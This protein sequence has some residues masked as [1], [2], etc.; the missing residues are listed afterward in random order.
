MFRTTIKSLPC[1][2]AVT[3]L[4]AVSSARA[5]YVQQQIAPSSKA[6]AGYAGHNDPWWKHAVVYEVYPR[7]FV[8]SDG[9]GV[10]D[11][12]GVTE[13]LD[14]LQQLG[15]DAIWLA[16]MYPSPQ[17]DFGYDI[18]DY[19]AVDP[20]Y[21]SLADFDR[22]LEKAKQ[23][24]LRI[25]LDMVLNHT[26]DKSPWFLESA[27]SRT[28]PKAAWYIWSDGVSAATA[29][30][31]DFQ[32]K[33]VQRGPKGQVVPPNNWTSAFGGS[34]WTWA[35][36]RQQFY[37]HM[38]YAGQPDLNWRNPDVDKAMFAVMRFWLD[39]G[40]AG[41]R[42]DAVPALFEDAR[43]RN[44]PD[45]KNV[46]APGYTWDLSEVHDVLR[47]MRTMMNSYPGQRVLIGELPEPTMEKLDLWYGGSAQ[48]E[49]QLPMNYFFGFRFMTGAMFTGKDELKADYSRNQLVAMSTQLHGSTPFVF[50]DNHDNVRSIDRL[51][52]GR[53]N[54]EIAKV[55][56]ALLLTVPGTAQIY[57]GQ[58]IGMVTTTPTGR[59]D[60]RDPVGRSQWPQNKGRDG[61]RT[62]MQW[63]PG[64]Q[65]GFSTN[66]KTWLPIPASSRTTN[67][68]TEQRR[69]DSLLNWYKALIALRRS[70]PAMREGGVAI[71]DEKNAD[72]LSFIR[73]A[74]GAKP[75]L[76]VLNMTE[77]PKLVAIQLKAAGVTNGVPR[78]LLSTPGF[79]APKNLGSVAL[80]PFCVWIAA[81][82]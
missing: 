73:T 79:A 58:E 44:N 38:F 2:I 19:E 10:G 43:L 26:S 71:V 5:I 77:N 68:Q 21:G 62:P 50:F 47:R 36:A 31:T 7:S 60:V 16:P 61:E 37:Y 67:V 13:H 59:E 45:P 53:H 69:P 27:S 64:P 8:D 54:T 29:D 81:I 24:N 35:P 9:D 75:V 63:T 12:N 56:A 51:G 55:T 11:L 33:E 66:S 20:Q 80:P 76:V 65:A 42:L 72:V 49:L 40:V 82:K 14:Y 18:S 4:M 57:Y 78:T 46:L 23:H 52:D 3:L 34:A 48:N 70:S 1:F 39:R 74:A 17:V 41:F 28:N 6:T 15:V 30:L 22:L 32:K 25:I